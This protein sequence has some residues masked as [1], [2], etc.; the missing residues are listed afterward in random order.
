[1]AAE[2]TA[3]APD[4]ETPTDI[5][6]SPNPTAGTRARRARKPKEKTIASYPIRNVG[7]IAGRELYSLFASPI[8]YLVIAFFLVMN[9]YLF[10]V[11][12]LTSKT[13]DMTSSFSDMAI[14]LLFLAPAITM[15]LLSEEQR[16]GT[17]ELL[18][19]SPLRETELVLG[20]WLGAM[21][22]W[23]VMLLLTVPY[24]LFLMKFGQPDMGP[25][26]GGYVGIFMLGGVFL[27]IGLLISSLTQNQIVSLA[28]TIG[29]LLVL[30]LL[31][32][33]GQNFA[34]GGP[35]TVIQY[36]ALSPHFD[37]FTTGAIQL[38]DLVYYTSIIIIALFLAVRS[39]ETRRWR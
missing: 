33:A 12:L 11:I 37:G 21:G 32:G 4:V 6:P 22:M 10:S 19:T 35:G 13:A 7:T 31:Q 1:D 39:V 9:G 8:A 25:I 5:A 18:L 3:P 27:A 34:T 30:W 26:L 20:K 17:I 24:P 28:I 14:V 2:I 36:I 16:T 29:I 38:K 23:L 15:R